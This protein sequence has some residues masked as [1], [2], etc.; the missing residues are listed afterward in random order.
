M[1][2]R[3]AEII[4][5]NKDAVFCDRVLDMVTGTGHEHILPDHLLAA[6]LLDPGSPVHRGLEAYRPEDLSAIILDNI[7]VAREPGQPPSE[8]AENTLAPAFVE[9]LQR[10]AYDNTGEALLAGLSP[11]VIGVLEIGEALEPLRRAFAQPAVPPPVGTISFFAEDGAINRRIFT[12]NALALI[13]AV[14]KTAAELGYGKISLPQLFIGIARH[15]ILKDYMTSFG[16]LSSQVID[17]LAR[18]IAKGKLAEKTSFTKDTISGSVADYISMVVK[19][20]AERAMTTVDE[21]LLVAALCRMESE[22]LAGYWRSCQ[23]DRAEVGRM[24]AVMKD[25]SPINPSREAGL[26]D[27]DAIIEKLRSRII[28]QEQ[29]IR[30]IMPFVRRWMLG[31]RF[32]NQPAGVVLLMGPPGVGKTELSKELAEIFYGDRNKLCFIEMNQLTQEHHVSKLI[33][34]SPEY[35]GPPSGKL[36][37]WIG[38]HPESII[39]LDE[40]EKAHENCFR[41]LLRLLSDG[42][43]QDGYGREYDATNNL[44][45]MTSNIGQETGIFEAIHCERQLFKDEEED[46]PLTNPTIRNLLA[47]KFAPEFISRLMNVVLFNPLGEDDFSRI[48]KIAVDKALKQVVPRLRGVQVQLENER[49]LLSHLADVALDTNQGARA[50]RGLIDTAIVNPLL[51]RFVR[52]PQTEQFTI[53]FAGGSIEITG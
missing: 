3:L 6:W 15:G 16:S 43:I 28:G 24:I 25:D 50:F 22:L 5:K 29:P 20:A 19:L 52:Q 2:D 17:E 32:D 27:F 1:N 53:T 10:E 26:P 48:A 18:K 42:R 40:I 44:I 45:I 34:S 12:A 46:N 33:G 36:T 31:V 41:V 7:P 4:N 13:E 35:V 23:L 8:I 37:N 38:E 39:L 49:E 21:P 9:R 30:H 11:E 51:D 47:S 14:E